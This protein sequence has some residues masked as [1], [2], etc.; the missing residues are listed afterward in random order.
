MP[1]SKCAPFIGPRH[2]ASVR[3]PGRPRLSP[4]VPLAA[5]RVSRSI[6]D[7]DDTGRLAPQGFSPTDGDGENYSR[8]WRREYC[9]SATMSAT[10]KIRKP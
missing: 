6:S 2:R 8:N 9:H 1:I 4:V 5:R 10:L 3:T 7:A